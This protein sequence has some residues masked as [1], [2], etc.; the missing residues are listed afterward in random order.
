MRFFSLRIELG[1]E[2]DAARE[3]MAQKEQ[4]EQRTGSYQQQAPAER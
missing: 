2:S 1:E 4:K 3:Q